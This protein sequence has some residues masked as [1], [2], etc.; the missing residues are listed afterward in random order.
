MNCT[1]FNLLFQNHDKYLHTVSP[2]SF[3]EHYITGDNDDVGSDDVVDASNIQVLQ[4]LIL[5]ENVFPQED[6]ACSFQGA[7]LQGVFNLINY[8]TFCL[9]FNSC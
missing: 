1:V 9:T 7:I 8:T 3:Y 2:V 6:L 4:D 5:G